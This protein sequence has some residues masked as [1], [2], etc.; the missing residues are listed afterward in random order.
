LKEVNKK[1]VPIEKM[2]NR[3]LHRKITSA[4]FIFDLGLICDALQ[5]LSELNLD[6]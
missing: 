3:R 6:L 5:V 2:H 4:E 1:I